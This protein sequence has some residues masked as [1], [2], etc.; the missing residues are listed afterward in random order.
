MALS[1]QIAQQKIKKLTLEIIR[2]NDNYHVY[3]APEITDQEYD[4]LK[5]ELEDLE[6][7]FPQFKLPNSPT[8]KV[9]AFTPSS[10]SKVTH[11]IPMLSLSNAFNAEELRAFD[12]KLKRRLAEDLNVTSTKE[13]D[14]EIEYVC[15]LKFDGLAVSLHYMD[16]ELFRASTR[17]DGQIG[18]DITEN[19]K[20]ISSVP[21]K[22][23]R[24]A[25]D[26]IEFRGEVFMPHSEFERLNAEREAAGEDLFANPRN[27]ASGSL[28][29]QDP[30]ITAER[31]L[32]IFLY[33]IGIC[34][35]LKPTTHHYLKLKIIQGLT[36]RANT[37][38][39]TIKGIEKVIQFCSDW[40]AKRKELPYDIDGIVIKLND[41][42][43]QQKM[44][45]NSHSPRWAIAYKFPAEEVETIIEDIQIQVGRTGALTPVAVMQPVLVDGSIIK[46][47]TLHNEDEI[48]KKDVKIG[49]RVMIR[50]AGD[51]IPEVVRVIKNK[52]TGQEKTFVMPSECPECGGEVYRKDSEAVSRC[53]NVNC[54]AQKLRA[55][56]HWASKGAMDIDG[57]GPSIVEQLFEAKFI[58]NPL[59]LYELTLE[60]VLQLDRMAEKSAQNL[61]DAIQ[62]SKKQDLQRLIHA[63]GITHVGKGTAKRLVVKF[64]S[65]EELVEATEEELA[66]TEDIGAITAKSIYEFFHVAHNADLV[67]KIKQLGLNIQTNT[68]VKKGKL[69]GLK[70]VFTGKLEQMGRNEI[71]ELVEAQGGET[72]SSISKDIAYLVAGESAGSKLD[73]A[74]KLGIKII[75]E[76][77]FFEMLS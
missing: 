72:S 18:E 74:Q 73:K 5:R 16:N 62:Q 52:R 64:S 6:K 23:D 77:E 60:K 15:E 66:N 13:D 20:T 40:I 19:I 49:D 10:F 51:V 21:Y 26:E 25:I 30:R 75:T 3:N 71:Q 7:K 9:G 45:S 28:R 33:D 2:H 14:I 46:H 31:K 8:D 43:L 42:A 11:K 41:V 48:N 76:K 29:Q 44:G 36:G 53:M 39:K 59:D 1:P 24:L 68:N 34:N 57:L 50:K 63:L 12:Q 22:L 65:L 35:G 27:A 55:I 69:N 67:M 56:Q 61:I 54:P 17:G 58:E 32:D 38:S 47:A 70:F 37:H 4:A